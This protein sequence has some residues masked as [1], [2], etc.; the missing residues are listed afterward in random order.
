MENFCCTGQFVFS[1]IHKSTLLSCLRTSDTSG[2]S[3][4]CTESCEPNKLRAKIAD[5]IVGCKFTSG[6]AK[7]KQD[8]LLGEVFDLFN[9]VFTHRV[10]LRIVNLELPSRR[11]IA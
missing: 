6:H 11:A 3:C 9:V 10:D 8:Q 5:V 1:E 4:K 2:V 7:S